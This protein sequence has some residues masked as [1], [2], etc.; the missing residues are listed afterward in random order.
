M[1][2]NV[3]VD[4]AAAEM[5]QVD[6]RVGQPEFWIRNESK[7]LIY[8]VLWGGWANWKQDKKSFFRLLK[9]FLLHWFKSLSLKLTGYRIL[10]QN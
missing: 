6:H 9:G 7:R 4:L 5:P 10:I 8:R 2:P 3:G 1:L